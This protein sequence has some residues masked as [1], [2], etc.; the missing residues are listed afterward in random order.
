MA[1]K[2]TP[3]M[4]K[5]KIRRSLTAILDPH[6]SANEVAEL[7][8][9]FNGLC[10]Y[11][12]VSIDASSR[13]G[14]L[15]HLVSSALG[16]S[17]DIHNHA[18]SCARCNG[19]EKRDEDWQSFLSRKASDASVAQA[20]RAHTLAWLAKT[21]PSPLGTTAAMQAEVIIQA[22]LASYDQAVIQM[23]ALRKRGA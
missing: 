13:T 23:R 5:N 1:A 15:D 14:H 11:C 12:G 17:N 19:D 16:G 4:A 2:D 22:A 7:W 9:Y 10:A 8:L 18:L 3:S 6:P 20:R 21:R